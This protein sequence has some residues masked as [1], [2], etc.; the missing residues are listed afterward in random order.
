MATAIAILLML[1]MTASMMIAPSVSAAK[2]SLVGYVSVSPNIV[3]LGNSV[4]VVAWI[5][6]TPLAIGSYY[7]DYKNMYVTFTKPDGT[8]DTKGPFTSYQEGSIFVSYTPDK[9]GV[10]SATLTFAGDETNEGTVSPPYKFTVQ[11][12][13][14]P[15]EPETPLPTEFWTRPVNSQNRDWASI[16]GQWLMS[17]YYA[18]GYN[19]SCNF[20]N[21]YSKAP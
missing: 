20:Y 13:P 14:V 10:W 17:E 2:R 9:L 5:V 6:P 8:N 4:T 16:A 7:P 11:Q 18:G 1:S 3:G 19:A 21:P 15:A 12:E